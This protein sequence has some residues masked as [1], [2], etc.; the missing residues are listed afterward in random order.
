MVKANTVL[1][2]IYAKVIHV[3]CC[4][5]GFHRI[6]VKIHGQVYELR[7]IFREAP[8]R[9]GMFKSEAPGIKL[10]PEPITTR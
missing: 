8:Y 4:V 1:K 2:N 3:T 5:H 6:V 9:V 7:S 10:P